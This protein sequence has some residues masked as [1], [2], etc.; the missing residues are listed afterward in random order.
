[1]AMALAC[2]SPL[3]I[4]DEPTTALDV[5]IQAQMLRLMQ[6]LQRELG[7][8]LL[9]ITHDL[10]VVAEIADEVAVMYTGQIV[11]YAQVEALFERPLHPYTRGLLAARPSLYGDRHAALQTIAGIVPVLTELPAGCRFAARCP[12]VEPICRERNPELLPV[13][14]LTRK[15]ACHVVEREAAHE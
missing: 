2:G 15:V 3:L 6:G 12:L 8:A 11:E 9:F 14:G 1:M 7:T 13:L 10:G 4:A 5:T